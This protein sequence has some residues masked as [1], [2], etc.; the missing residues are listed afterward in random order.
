MSK[1]RLSKQQN[2]NEQNRNE[3]IYT[4]RNENIDKNSEINTDRNKERDKVRYGFLNKFLI[5]FLKKYNI[6]FH[7]FYIEPSE[8]ESKFKTDLKGVDQEKLEKIVQENN[9]YLSI[10]ETLIEDIISNDDAETIKYAFD[11]G[12]LDVDARFK[13]GTTPLFKAC[14]LG[15]YKVAKQL[16]K[17][18]ADVNLTSEGYTPLSIACGANR[19]DIVKLLLENGAKVNFTEQKITPLEVAIAQNNVQIVKILLDKGA[20]P[21]LFC[22]RPP[23]FAACESGNKEIINLLISHGANMNILYAPFRPITVDNTISL[24]SYMVY[25]AKEDVIKLLID[26]GIDLNIKNGNGMT[27]LSY[28]SVQSYRYLNDN[29]IKTLIKNRTTPPSKEEYKIML[30]RIAKE[31]IKAGADINSEDN[32]GWTPLMFACKYGEEQL[33]KLFLKAGADPNHRSK[34]GTTPLSIAAVNNQI[35]VI[36]FLIEAGA[37][38]NITSSTGKTP[39]IK[40]TEKGYLEAVRTLIE[41]GAD[42]DIRDEEGNTALSYAIITQR[43]DIIR[44]LLKNKANPNVKISRSLTLKELLKEGIP[45]F[46]AENLKKYGFE[47]NSKIKISF[48]CLS[49]ALFQGDIDIIESLLENGADVELI[50]NGLT[51][52]M[53]AVLSNKKEIVKSILKYKPNINAKGISNITAMH[54][55]A[56]K[57]KDSDIIDLLINYGADIEARDSA[58]LPPIVYAIQSNNTN[59]AK[60]LIKYGAKTNFKFP[61]GRSLFV[62]AVQNKFSDISLISGGDDIEPIALDFKEITKEKS[63]RSIKKK[64]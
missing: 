60:A 33:V 5:K 63:K 57:N 28:L 7:S 55:A 31:L 49:F 13:D 14:V 8:S 20:D 38:P 44:L 2:T 48:S 3:K 15:K 26:H 51:P 41:N 19:I 37:D 32:D 12:I 22:L 64:D 17:L 34:A 25:L 42:L 1:K 35:G 56:M 54:L 23:L 53:I 24:L 11:Y 29:T 52:L 16:I 18:G 61:D 36:R 30:F 4:D 21:N 58:G 40:A 39:L 59:A 27:A 45:L 47:E 43:K 50:D 62:Y 9:A 10:L 46:I 6:P